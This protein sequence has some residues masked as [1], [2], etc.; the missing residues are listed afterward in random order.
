MKRFKLMAIISCFVFVTL[1]ITPQVKADEFNKKT[2]LTFSE[3]FEVPGVDAQILPAG[4]YVFKIVDA[5]G[6]RD[7]VQISDA[8]E[9]HVYTTILAIANW[10]LKPTDKTVLTF[11]E[12]G[13]GQPEAIKAWFYPGET[14]GQEF[15]YPKKRAIELAKIVN[16]PVLAM[17][18]DT[19][20]VPVET[21][22]IVEIA[23]VQ[24]TGVEVPVTA[25]IEP[26]P[27]AEVAQAQTTPAT[28]VAQALPETASSLPLFALIGVLSLFAGFTL[29]IITKRAI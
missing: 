19:T 25:V 21:L 18:V 22:R 7:I 16:E 29:L 9:T 1:A 2:I 20:A 5:I 13:E 10:R 28:L 4:T 8:A 24:P 15:V 6:D 17:P 12:R 23:A 3:P 26:P 11:G 14:W 27:A